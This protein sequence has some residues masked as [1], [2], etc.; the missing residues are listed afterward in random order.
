MLVVLFSVLCFYRFRIL[1]LL[2]CLFVF[3]FCCLSVFVCP[4]RSLLVNYYYHFT[5]LWT[6]SG[7]T[8]VSRYQKKNIHPFTPSVVINHP[9]SSFF[10]FIFT[11]HCLFL[12]AHAH[13]IA[14]CFA[15]LPKLSSNPSFYLNPLFGTLSF[16]LMPR[17]HLTILISAC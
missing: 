10:I 6:L 8:R 1:S 17:I 16:S 9:L 7:A 15:V 2:V 13:T 14:T 4:L 5:A 3:L 11:K 12:A